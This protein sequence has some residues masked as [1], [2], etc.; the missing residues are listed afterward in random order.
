MSLRL[1]S[2]VS[3][4]AMRTIREAFEELERTVTPSDAKEVENSTPQKVQLAALETENRLGAY[5]SLRNMCR[6]M[7]LFTGLQHYS[8]SIEV[9]CNGTP[10]LPWI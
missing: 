8:Q 3:P 2:K 4:P 9:L 10:F 1:R 7:P 6:I 5:Q